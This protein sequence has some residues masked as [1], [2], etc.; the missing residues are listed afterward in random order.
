MPMK[1]FEPK[2]KWMEYIK[3]SNENSFHQTNHEVLGDSGMVVMVTV[4]KLFSACIENNNNEP[5]TI[6]KLHC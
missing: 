2:Q 4:L 5:V 3:K 1:I 6:Q